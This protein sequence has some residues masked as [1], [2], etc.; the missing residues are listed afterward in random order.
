MPRKTPVGA[1]IFRGHAPRRD[2]LRDVVRV[3]REAVDHRRRHRI[4]EQLPD[5]VEAGLAGHDA[6][7][8]ALIEG[9]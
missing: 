5:E 4:K 1:E 6:A 7:S 2:V 8:T 3:A 9:E